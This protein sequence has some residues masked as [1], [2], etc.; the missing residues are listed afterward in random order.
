LTTPTPTAKQ[1]QGTAVAPN[2]EASPA[3]QSSTPDPAP[4]ATSEPVAAAP[5]PGQ[6][7]DG[8]LA[9]GHAILDSI[10]AATQQAQVHVLVEDAKIWAASL[11]SFVKSLA[12]SK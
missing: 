2:T 6:K 5:T 8:F 1:T 7:L 3:T 11:V 4:A 10:K 12:P 9:E